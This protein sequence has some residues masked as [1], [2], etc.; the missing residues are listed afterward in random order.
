MQ[1]PCPHCDQP[2]L[3]LLRVVFIG[4][5]LRADEPLLV[6]LADL[7][8]TSGLLPLAVCRARGHPQTAAAGFAARAPAGRRARARQERRTSALPQGPLATSPPA[9]RA[10]TALSTHGQHGGVISARCPKGGRMVAVV[11]LHAGGEMRVCVESRM[12]SGACSC[13]GDD[14]QAAARGTVEG[15]PRRE[16]NAGRSNAPHTATSWP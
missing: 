2:D 6:T 9:R 3:S 1:P 8:R 14:H 15:R 12:R 11:H 5:I 16:P 4:E 10:P 13:G 7:L